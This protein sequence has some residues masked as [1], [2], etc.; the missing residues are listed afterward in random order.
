LDDRRLFDDRNVLAGVRRGR[1]RENV[2]RRDRE[3]R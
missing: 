3:D 2:G 1:A